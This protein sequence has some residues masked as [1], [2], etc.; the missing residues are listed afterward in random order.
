MQSNPEGALAIPNIDQTP[1]PFSNP[2]ELLESIVTA[3][4]GHAGSFNDL[5]PAVRGKPFFDNQDVPYTGTLDP[6]LLADI[7]ADVGRFKA[8]PSALNY[9]HHYYKPSGDLQIP[10]LMLSTSRDPVVPGFHQILYRDLVGVSGHSDLL[11]QREID[12][13][14]HC[15]FTPEELATAFTDLVLWVEFGIQPAP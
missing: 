9:L 3:L 13:Y 6:G 15:V 11:V 12:R 4:A 1:V 2:A 7:N 10:M 14:G 5:S 8:S